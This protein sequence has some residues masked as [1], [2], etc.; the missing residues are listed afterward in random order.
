M[1][2]IW[3]VLAYGV[4]LAAPLLVYQGVVLD[5][6]DV[7]YA[8]LASDMAEGH[9]T[10]G[11]NT[12]TYRLGFLVPMAVLYQI[13]GVH[14]WTT[15]A[16]PLLSSLASVLIAGY[17]A[18]RLY[19]GSA[20]AW[21]ALLC[22]FSPILYRIGS[23]GLAD[24]LAGFL[25][26][27]F[28]V[29]WV[30]LVAN[31]VE[32]RRGWAVLSGL[33]CAWAVAT[34]ESIAP[35]A[36][37]TLLGFLI[38]GWR[39]STLHEFPLKAWLFG[40]CA[41]AGS[42]LLTLWWYTGT[43]FYFLHAAL[44]GYNLAGAPWLQP[45]EGMQLVIRL[46][47]LAIL[48]ASIE[49]YLFAVFPV[50]V[51]AA[52]MGKTFSQGGDHSRLYLV[53]AVASILVILSH[54]STSVSRWSPVRLELRY[55]SPIIMP[56]GILVAGTCLRLPF[57]RLSAVVR[58]A[59]WLVGLASAGLLGIGL[60]RQDYM[61]VVG[62]AAAILATFSVVLA[63]RMPRPLLPTILVLLLMGNW[64]W[65]KSQQYLELVQRNSIIRKEAEAV[66]WGAGEAI[67]TDSLTAQIL[68]YLHRFESLPQV[69]TWK[70]EREG[71][72]PFYWTKRIDAPWTE[73]YWL[74][75]HP[76][77]ARNQAARW[78]TEVPLWVLQE[79]A[80][81]RL[82]KEFSGEPGGGVLAVGRGRG[83]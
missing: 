36:L 7:L 80:R 83:G 28:V 3:A 62:A 60:A 57:V 70:G 78:G 46:T 24:M 22:G 79:V 27:L 45:P 54:F 16:F 73:N 10:F 18:D 30:L 68:P 43:P 61:L 67:L 13:F 21:A 74:V 5:G 64:G 23:T 17:A 76:T 82:I 40:C 41:V 33:A 50:V 58:S 14:D 59:A 2:S 11:I 77:E 8:R 20:G 15:V 42:Y 26:G 1:K 56:A 69:A 63:H 75:W 9:P 19:G 34:R 52:L 25:Y 38:I 66:P 37:L 53:L 6:D 55:G 4:A 47:G 65:F 32:R 81:G 72:R 51:V 71:E 44:G 29:G 39:Q 31:R 49:G 35:M 48:R 12:H